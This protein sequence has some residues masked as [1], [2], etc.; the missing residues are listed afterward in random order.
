MPVIEVK[1]YDRRVTE[2]S[3]PKMIE[4]LTN[5]LHETSGAAVEHINVIIQ[6]FRRSTGGSAASRASSGRGRRTR[7]QEAVRAREALRRSDRCSP[8]S[9]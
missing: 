2:E 6:G 8:G 3:V 5:A 7:T 4:A 1:L 9:R